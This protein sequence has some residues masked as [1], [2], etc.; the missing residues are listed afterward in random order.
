[1]YREKSG[2]ENGLTLTRKNDGTVIFNVRITED[3]YVIVN[4][5]FYAEGKKIDIADS[6][7]TI[8]DAPRAD[9][10]WCEI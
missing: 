7:V 2:K 10:K 9:Y 6:E 8:D 5:I 1:M 3:R 4:G